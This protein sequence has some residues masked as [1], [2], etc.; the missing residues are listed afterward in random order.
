M[1]IIVVYLILG[2]AYLASPKHIKVVACVINFF[3]PDPIPGIDEVVMI[4]GLL[5]ESI[6]K[7]V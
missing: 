4:A 1:A 7:D 6:V 5:A 2:I 3:V